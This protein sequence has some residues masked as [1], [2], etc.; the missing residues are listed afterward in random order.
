MSMDGNDIHLLPL[1]GYNDF[2]NSSN[3]SEENDSIEVV[4]NVDEE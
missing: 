1:D 3:E 4:S 2:E